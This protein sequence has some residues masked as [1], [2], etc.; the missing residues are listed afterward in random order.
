MRPRHHH[1]DEVEASYLLPHGHRRGGEPAR[2]PDSE[3]GVCAFLAVLTDKQRIGLEGIC[4]QDRVPRAFSEQAG[5]SEILESGKQRGL[6]F[7]VI[8]KPIHPLQLLQ[9]PKKL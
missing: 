1:S 3:E 5:I 9:Q 8:A 2:F 4:F 7:D 6:T